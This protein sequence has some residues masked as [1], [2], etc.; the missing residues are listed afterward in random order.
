M[1]NWDKKIVGVLLILL[2]IGMAY[3]SAQ[4]IHGEVPYPKDCHYKRVFC[5][6]ENL[7]F[8]QGGY[9]AIGMVN[10]AFSLLTA[11]IGYVAFT[12]EA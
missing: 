3:Y 5:G 8:E 10:M 4:V 7:I 2:G 6:L 11:L 9:F 1:S 12:S